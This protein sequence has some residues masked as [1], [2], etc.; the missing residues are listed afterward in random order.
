MLGAQLLISLVVLG[1]CVLEIYTKWLGYDT[2]AIQLIVFITGVWLG[3]VPAL[4][5]RLDS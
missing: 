3:R 2:L 1:F 5:R 4:R